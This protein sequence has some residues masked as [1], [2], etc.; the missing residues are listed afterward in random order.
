MPQKT[1]AT[2]F[3]ALVLIACTTSARRPPADRAPPAPQQPAAAVE[4]P[5]A[6]APDH[7]IHAAGPVATVD[8]APITAEVF[9]ETVRRRVRVY[10]YTT[11]TEPM[12]R[13]LAADIVDDLIAS[14]LIDARLDAEGVTVDEAVVDQKFAY[15]RSKFPSDEEY[16][17]FMATN[18]ATEAM[19]REHMRQDARVEA[20]LRERDGQGVDLDEARRALVEELKREATIARHPENIVVVPVQPD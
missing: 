8:G 2:A 7:P 1:V 16:R 17:A 6:P 3:A 4:A 5:D 13:K 15:F 11:L 19:V 10:D 9:D 18:R 14:R 20:Y 12:G